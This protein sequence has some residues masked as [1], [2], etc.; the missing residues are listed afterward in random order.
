MTLADLMKKSEA[1]L[2][3]L[4]LIMAERGNLAALGMISE[5]RKYANKPVRVVKGRKVPI[6]TVGEVFWMGSQDYS[7]YGDPWGIYTKYRCGIRDWRG[8]VYWTSLDNVE[9]IEE[10]E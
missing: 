7:K 4:S 3:Q 10:A 6:G 9:V 1:E 2:D 8:N 5:V